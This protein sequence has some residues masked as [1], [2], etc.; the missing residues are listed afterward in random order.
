MTVKWRLHKHSKHK[1][2]EGLAAAA[3]D[4]Q[5]RL[6][7]KCGRLEDARLIAVA[8]ELLVLLE[9]WYRMADAGEMDGVEL[10]L[11]M[12]ATSETIAKIEGGEL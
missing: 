8:P 11:L 5:S 9:E 10:L 6:V 1:V 12:A 2:V 4:G 7:A 3:W